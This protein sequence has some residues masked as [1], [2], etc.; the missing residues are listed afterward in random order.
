[1][2]IQGSKF[3]PVSWSD[4]HKP[5][6]PI[7]GWGIS[8]KAPG[9]HRYKPCGY[10]GDIHPFKTEKEAK[11]TCDRLNLESATRAKEE[12]DGRNS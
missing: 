4:I 10:Q 9:E 5:G 12:R 7:I 2:S 8:R 6:A 1:M 3:R 11:A